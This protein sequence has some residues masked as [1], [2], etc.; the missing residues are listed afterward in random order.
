MRKK[1]A[2]KF[3]RRKNK[4]I[5]QAGKFFKHKIRLYGCKGKRKK[6]TAQGKEHAKM[7]AAKTVLSQTMSI[8]VEDGFDGEGTAQTKAHTYS[9]IK[10]D[11]GADELVKAGTALGSLMENE[12][13]N[14]VVTEKA[15]VAEAE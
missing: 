14:I 11:A 5:L 12:V 6:Q 8:N 4:K 15:E 2:K 10:K 1:I 7:A 13:V 3:L 9:G